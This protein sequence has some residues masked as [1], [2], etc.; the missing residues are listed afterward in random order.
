MSKRLQDA[1]AGALGS[2][3][4]VA[5]QAALVQQAIAITNLYFGAQA[6]SKTGQK[7]PDWSAVLSSII[8][9]RA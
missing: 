9:N 5:N 2:G 4:G 7:M 8:G 3:E 6:M 1:F